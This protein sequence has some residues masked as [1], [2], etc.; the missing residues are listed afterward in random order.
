MA[1]NDNN[2]PDLPQDDSWL[3]KLI[4]RVAPNPDKVA[5]WVKAIRD[6]NPGVDRDDLA[7][8]VADQI[9]WTFAKQ[10]AALALPGAIPGLGTIV[11]IGTE[12]GALGADLALMIRNETY[13]VFALGHVYGIKGRETLIQDTLI[14]I[15]LWTN[16]L[17]LSKSGTIRIGTKVVEANFKKRFP[18][19][20]L[21]AINRKVGTTVLTKYGTKRGAV[22][23]GKLIPFGV[24]ATVGGAFNYL[25]MKAFGKNCLK[26]FRMKTGD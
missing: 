9:T 3:Y 25:T 4:G 26:H 19:K 17:T 14:C 23:V 1:D 10:G 22:A 8:Y 7:E 6:E 13:L 24:G 2:V 5:D 21:Q 12:L 11:Q 15:G 18:A 20:I 16:A